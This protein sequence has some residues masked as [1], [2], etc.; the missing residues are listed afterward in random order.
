MSPLVKV[1]GDRV[2][3]TTPL[4]L[5]L[6]FLPPRVGAAIARLNALKFSLSL[7][8]TLSRFSFFSFPPYQ[9]MK[10]EDFFY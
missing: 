2:C 8:G 9:K 4:S 10:E 3:R 1:S 7:P 5:S 6:L